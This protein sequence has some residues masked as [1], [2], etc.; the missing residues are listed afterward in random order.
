MGMGAGAGLEAPR[1]LARPSHGRK[2]TMEAAAL[3]RHRHPLLPLH[4][5]TTAN[6]PPKGPVAPATVAP[7]VPIDPIDPRPQPATVLPEEVDGASVKG[8]VD[9]A[10][11]A[12]ESEVA[13]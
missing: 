6:Q 8:A 2:P 4:A 13:P 1:R 5:T 7:P 12:P 10:T 11:A 3:F 9:V